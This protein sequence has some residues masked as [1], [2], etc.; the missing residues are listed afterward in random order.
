MGETPFK[1]NTQAALFKAIVKG[2]YTPLD[3]SFTPQ[4]RDLVNK[5]LTTNS[6]KRIQIA[7]VETHPWLGKSIDAGLMA[8]DDDDLMSAAANEAPSVQ[9]FSSLQ[10]VL[11][12]MSLSAP[13]A[14]ASAAK[15][16]KA[17]E[18]VSVSAGAAYYKHQM[19]CIVCMRA[20]GWGHAWQQGSHG[21]IQHHI[22]PGPGMAPCAQALLVYA[23]HY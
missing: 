8:G 5:M 20:N 3:T 13:P 23:A 21:C 15:A 19:C 2:V 14:A 18:T 17:G 6:E 9:S 10:L 22:R 16:G 1:G 12:G 11:P 7:A 4:C